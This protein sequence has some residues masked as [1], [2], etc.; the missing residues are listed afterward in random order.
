MGQQT[1]QAKEVY[2]LI[3]WLFDWLIEYLALLV[4]SQ[5]HRF[6][7]RDHPCAC[8]ITG[9]DPLKVCVEIIIL[10][11]GLSRLG[12]SPGQCHCS[13]ERHF[14]QAVPVFTLPCTAVCMGSFKFNAE[15]GVIQWQIGISSRGGVG[16]KNNPSC[17]CLMLIKQV[18]APAW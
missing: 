3:N 13:S 9:N 11:T 4:F 12:S 6:L 17:S 16:S 5:L 10:D 7:L 14:T 2:W 8:G 1:G 18:Y 15:A